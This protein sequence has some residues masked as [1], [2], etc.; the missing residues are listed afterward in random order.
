MMKL[1][2]LLIIVLLNYNITFSQV[3]RDNLEFK[4]NIVS[5]K[6][7]YF[8]VD[9][10]DLYNLFTWELNTSNKEMFIIY[11]SFDGINW[12][13]LIETEGNKY[14]EYNY[15]WRDYDDYPNI[16]YYRI[17]LTNNELYIELGSLYIKKIK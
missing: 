8:E 10:F 11:K 2:F 16:V 17:Y 5:N 9:F 3:S 14:R 7:K 13:K 6:L 12:N 1:I 4:N 15:A